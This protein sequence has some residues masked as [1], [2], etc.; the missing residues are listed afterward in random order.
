[1]F[2]RINVIQDNAYTYLTIST[3]P[4]T[5]YIVDT[6]D[7]SSEDPIERIET[8]THMVET[9]FNGYMTDSDI[10]NY[11]LADTGDNYGLSHE[12]LINNYRVI[13]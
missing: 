13:Y 8:L 3:T 12:Y 9:E 2:N 11:L 4:E 10:I 5:Y 6:L 7:P 1:M